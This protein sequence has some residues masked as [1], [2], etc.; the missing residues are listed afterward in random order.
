M[1]KEDRI[2][3]AILRDKFRLCEKRCTAT[4]TDFLTPAEAAE[5]EDIC[6]GLCAG[7]DVEWSLEGGWE[8]AE[9]R[10]CMFRPAEL[11]V[12][13]AATPEDQAGASAD[14]PDSGSAAELPICVLRI[15]IPKGSP[16]LTHRD[17]LGSLL[18][19]GIERAV[20]GDIFVRE[21]G[22][23]AVV[24]SDMADY[25]AQNL[26]SVGRAS[27]SC[28]VLDVSQLITGVQ[29]T[30]EIR[31][32]VA[33]LRLDS[34]CASA[35]RTARGKAQDA[36]KAGLVSVNGR[37]CLKPDTELKEGDRISC[38]GKGRAVLAEVGGRTRKDRITVKLNQIS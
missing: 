22:A 10:I 2:L 4:W 7:T 34:I 25:L 18:G 32:T 24:L 13:S 3:S 37:Q 29:Q 35:F 8:D 27:V 14:C 31:D 26:V 11:W 23:D 28:E 30:K 17:Y 12:D 1:N 33:S 16:K 19:L 6:R 21:D 15:S 38:R 9:R 36:I 5:A 20:T